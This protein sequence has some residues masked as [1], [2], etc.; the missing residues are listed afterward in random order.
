[1]TGRLGHR[2]V[3]VLGSFLYGAYPLLNGFAQ[4]ARLYWAASIAGGVVWGLANGGL[5][6]RLMERVPED[7][8]PAHMALHNL[9][10]NLG[11]L[12]GALAGPLLTEYFGLRNTLIISAFLRFLSGGIMLLWS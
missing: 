8:R 12:L 7:D 11:I 2:N 5:V 9:V 1:V 4:D 10:L 3:L 6:N